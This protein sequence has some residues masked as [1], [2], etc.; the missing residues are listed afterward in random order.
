MNAKQ[1][2][3][4]MANPKI[5]AEQMPEFCIAC[6]HTVT[7]GVATNKKQEQLDSGCSTSGGKSAGRVQ[8]SR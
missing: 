6:A 4:N 8:C 3:I 5:S 2:M 7:A 1:L